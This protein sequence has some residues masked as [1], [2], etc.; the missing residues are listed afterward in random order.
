MDKVAQVVDQIEESKR[1][2]QI[3]KLSDLRMAL[4]L[5]DNVAEVLMH[6]RAE[7]EIAWSDH[8]EY[9]LKRM[10]SWQHAQDPHFLEY[11]TEVA[12]R[13]ISS[14]HKREIRQTFEAKPKFLSEDRHEI[15]EFLART[16]GIIHRYR[17]KAYHRDNVRKETLRTIVLLLFELVCDLVVALPPDHLR[18]DPS[19]DRERLEKQYGISAHEFTQKATLVKVLPVL[20]GALPLSLSDLRDDL[21]DHLDLRIAELHDGVMII[22][23]GV[24]RQI[25]SLEA[26]EAAKSW[27][28]H[29]RQDQYSTRERAR[30]EAAVSVF[31]PRSCGRWKAKLP[32]LRRLDDKRHLFAVFADNEEE[33]EP[34]EDAVFGVVANIDYEINSRM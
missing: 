19:E 16:I 2:I 21:A 8:W 30:R 5:L 33:I 10:E 6:R 24:A 18:I 4:I 3:G 31:E 20:K 17:N 9:D 23:E 15:E 34:V 28:S 22:S 11:K 32:D 14:P 13:V 29:V 27:Y 12:G 7:S 26:V 1:L 25:S